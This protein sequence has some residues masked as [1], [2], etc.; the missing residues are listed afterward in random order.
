MSAL[1]MVLIL[2]T[3]PVFP[4]F[5]VQQERPQPKLIDGGKFQQEINGRMSVRWSNATLRDVI[6]RIVT[7][8]GFAMVR[9]RR[10]NPDRQIQVN[11]TQD[12]ARVVLEKIARSAEGRSVIVG[13]T[14]YLG[15][16]APAD[17]LRT[18]IA[19]RRDEL[20][21]MTNLARDRQRLLRRQ[22]IVHWQDLDRPVDLLG[23]VA[24]K[25]GLRIDGLERVPHDLWTG[26]T[27]L[28]ED[29]AAALSLILIQFDL[30]FQWRDAATAIE[31]VP[32]PDEVLI[33]DSH[34]PNRQS[35]IQAFRQVQKAFPELDVRLEAG[36]IEFAGTKE[37][38]EAVEA[39]L[40]PKFKKRVA[41]QPG[42]LEIVRL[43]LR[44][45][46]VPAISL[47]RDLEKRYKLHFIYDREELKR[48]GVDLEQKVDI[49]VKTVTLDKYLNAIFAPIGAQ[50]VREGHQVTVS[51][52]DP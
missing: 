29:A 51:A 24:A 18:L 38:H 20:S 11:S 6:A 44:V 22:Q 9:D 37:Q 39:L 43:S 16:Q 49:D 36:K 32:V 25:A 47:I 30:T 27:F 10:L 28:A 4:D 35:P 8:Q 17:K 23:V 2:S 42:G 3:V 40:R 48:G 21:R 31:I 5:S 19:L 12:T 33:T 15:P 14:I 50:A 7:Q 45:V 13:S 41:N 46:G 26:G 1:P 34:R 52:A